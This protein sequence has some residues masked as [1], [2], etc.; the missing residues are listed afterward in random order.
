MAI[1]WYSEDTG[2][3]YPNREALMEEEAYGWIVVALL[4]PAYPYK[5]ATYGLWPTQREAMNA[6][7]RLKN[8]ERRQ[9]RKA[10]KWYGQAYADEYHK[11]STWR[12]RPL[13]KEGEAR[14][15]SE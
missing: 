6:R 8:A 12:V 11:P 1:P 14:I 15:S 13:W 4:D 10:V 3:T 9:H 2:K 7:N 5:V